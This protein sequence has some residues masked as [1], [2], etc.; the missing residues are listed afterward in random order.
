MPELRICEDA[1]AWDGFVSQ[2]TDASV[3]QAWAWG[4][5]KSRWCIE[6]AKFRKGKQTYQGDQNN[7]FKAN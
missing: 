5:L 2:A 6:R 7:N 3:L 1:S 4:S